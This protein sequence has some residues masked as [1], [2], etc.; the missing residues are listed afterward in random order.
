MELTPQQIDFL[1]SLKTLD[2]SDNIRIK[3][4]IK[5]TL[6]KNDMII[7]LLNNKE[8]EEQEADPSDYLGVNILPYY[9]IHE[10]L[11]NVQN[12]ICYEVQTREEYRYKNTIKML[13]V[14]FYVLCDEKTGIDKTTGIARHDL[15]SALIT[16]DFNWSNLFGK[17][18]HLVSDVPN[19]T[20]ND[21]STRTL[22]FEGEFPNNIVKSN[23]NTKSTMVI[24]KTGG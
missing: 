10:T 6:I 23:V 8:L 13:Q 3:E 9:L 19:V 17:Q 21:Y 12:I 22:T 1:R 5:K 18:I 4:I 11:H 16:H 14:V 2:D 20:D 7:Y 24:N 15:L